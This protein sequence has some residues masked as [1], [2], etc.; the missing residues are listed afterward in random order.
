MLFRSRRAWLIVD[1][2]DLH[3]FPTRRSS[4]LGSAAYISRGRAVVSAFKMHFGGFIGWVVWL[5]IHIGFLTGWRNRIGALFGWWYAFTRDLR[6]NRGFTID[7]MPIAA[8]SPA[9]PAASSP[10]TPAG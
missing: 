3:S 7:D 2:R 4:D 5:F 8:Y 6:R 9:D 10:K 1:H